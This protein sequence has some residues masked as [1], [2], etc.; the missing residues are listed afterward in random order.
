M[1]VLTVAPDTVALTAD[2]TQLFTVTGA[3]ATTAIEVTE[4]G[5]ITWS[6]GAGIGTIVFGHGEFGRTSSETVR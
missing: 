2:Q 1:A 3:D 4:I 5:T 6:G